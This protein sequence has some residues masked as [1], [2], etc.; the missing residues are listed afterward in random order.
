MNYHFIKHLTL[1][2]F[3]VL[4]APQRSKDSCWTSDGAF[5]NAPP[6]TAS[7]AAKSA[8]ATSPEDDNSQGSGH[9]SFHITYSDLGD[10]AS[11]CRI[12]LE[13]PDALL[14]STLNAVKESMLKK[15]T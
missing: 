10:K 13:I 1:L 9:Q 5:K 7:A 15:K 6:F 3:E 4:T 11:T 8:S 2:F 12:G 14:E